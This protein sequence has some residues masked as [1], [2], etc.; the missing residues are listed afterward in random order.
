MAHAHARRSGLYAAL[1]FCQLRAS[2]VFPQVTALKRW[3]STCSGV[4]HIVI[5]MERQGFV[6][7]LHRL[8]DDGWKAKFHS[9][10]M[11]AADGIR[12]A[13][14]SFEAVQ[15][16]AWRALNPTRM[17]TPRGKRDSRD[18]CPLTPSH[19]AVDRRRQRG[20]AASMAD[21]RSMSLNGFRT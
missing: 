1:G 19:L 15:L 11:L 18:R 21:S 10:A 2:P 6:V 9:H 13:P 12:T 16:A 5:G 17:P 4:G 7:S 14:T 3:M 20:S 8:V